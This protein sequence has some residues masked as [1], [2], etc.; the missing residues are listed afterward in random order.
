MALRK[1]KLEGIKFGMLTVLYRA[2][3]YS[4][5]K[6]WTC[7]CDCGNLHDTT[8]QR[9]K[10]GSTKSCGCATS[11]MLSESNRKH[12]GYQDGKNTPEY[13]SFIAMMHRCYNDKRL[14]WENYGGRGIIVEEESWLEESPNGFLNFLHD[15]GER[16]EGTSLDRIDVDRGYCKENCRW[17]NRRTQ[18]YNR[19]QEKTE[20]N[21]SKYRGVS[22]S[23]DRNKPWV[24]RIGD[25]NGGYI[26]IGQFASEQEAAMAYNKKAVE[27][28]GEGAILNDV[29]EL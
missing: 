4:K 19:R 14:G 18:S 13:Q 8:H 20:K 1:L 15:M 10:N 9:L 25:G 27:I 3:D 16:P 23:K 2:Q 26:W 21:T 5:S 29:S 6:K 28:H 7:K 22:F 17:S 11:Q 24:A 12:G